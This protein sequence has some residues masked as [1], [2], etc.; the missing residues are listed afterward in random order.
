MW[1]K[2]C[3]RHRPYVVK[4][5]GGSHVWKDLL[6]ARDF[7]NQEIL[8]E[9]RECHTSVLHVH[10]T[11]LDA[12]QYVLPISQLDATIFNQEICRHTKNIL[13]DMHFAEDRV[14]PL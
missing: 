6:Q 14:M 8:W 9:P 10:W 1:N 13:R 3:K 12:L 2:Y 4:W 5:N 11:Q 7:F